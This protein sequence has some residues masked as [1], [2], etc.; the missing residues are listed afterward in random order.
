MRRE[1][2][3][4]PESLATTPAG[5]GGKHPGRYLALGV[6][7]AGAGLALMPGSPD[8]SSSAHSRRAGRDLMAG[9]GRFSA[10]QEGNGE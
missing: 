10:L 8:G 4:V 9:V 3:S 5:E 2:D 6:I 7:S 1:E